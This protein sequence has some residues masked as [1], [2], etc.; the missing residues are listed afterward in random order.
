MSGPWSTPKQTQPASSLREVMSEQAAESPEDDELARALA[1][2]MKLAEEEK[3]MSSAFSNANDQ[4]TDCTSD[5]VLARM[6]QLQFD[7][8]YQSSTVNQSPKAKPVTIVYSDDDEDEGLECPDE[9]RDYIRSVE[10]AITVGGRGYATVNGQMITKHDPELCGHKNTQ[11]I[12][13]SKLTFQIQ[14]D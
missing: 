12:T 4:S 8:E 11:K 1:E 14:Y 13:V 7:A 9:Q 2:S 10:R 6:L 3:A 5:V